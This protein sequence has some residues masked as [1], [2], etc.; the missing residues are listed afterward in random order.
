MSTS[1]A[2]SP[3][4]KLLILY[5]RVVATFFPHWNGAT[6]WRIV[7]GEMAVD[8]DY[9]FPCTAWADP[10][11]RI[12][13]VNLFGA[14]DEWNMA[15]LVYLAAY[16]QVCDSKAMTSHGREWEALMYKAARIGEEGGYK[17]LPRLVRYYIASARQ[18]KLSL[19]NWMK[20]EAG[21]ACDEAILAL[22]DEESVRLGEEYIALLEWDWDLMDEDENEN[23]R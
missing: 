11:E 19:R 17:L 1:A 15:D 8:T 13:E 20:K 22:T 14:N 16:A 3:N 12:L 10:D 7:N 2:M 4:V 18:T 5:A 6:A 21:K 23:W 9:P